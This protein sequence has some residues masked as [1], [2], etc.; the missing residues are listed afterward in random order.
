VRLLKKMPKIDQ[1][2][3]VGNGSASCTSW[4]GV[5]RQPFIWDCNQFYARLGL[6]AGASRVEVATAYLRLDG[7]RDIYLTNAAE[8]L[9]N[10]HSKRAYDALPLGTF[11]AD[12]IRLRQEIV[13]NDAHGFDLDTPCGWACYADDEV[14][15]E[16]VAVFAANVWRCLISLSLWMQ[17]VGNI[18]FAVGATKSDARVTVVG[19]RN[20]A[21]CPLT[22]PLS[23]DYVASIARGLAS[24][25][26]KS[27]SLL[28]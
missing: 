28:T 9:I 17:G 23:V 11:W 8:V 10:K 3:L 7:Y 22:L 15:D 20:V 25:M 21:F 27:T 26:I 6:P 18:H 5:E 24:E 12:D 4:L 16:E 2:R 19:F 1:R 13:N 14:S